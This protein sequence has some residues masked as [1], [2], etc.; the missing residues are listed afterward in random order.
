MRGC[1]CSHMR[2]RLVGA[3]VRAILR[4]QNGGNS[5]HPQQS[6]RLTLKAQETSQT[7]D[8]SLSLSCLSHTKLLPRGRRRERQSRSKRETHSRERKKKIK[9]R[10]FFFSRKKSEGEREPLAT[11]LQRT[12]KK[13]GEGKARFFF[14]TCAL[15]A[16]SPKLHSRD[17]AVGA[18]RLFFFF[19]SWEA[20]WTRFFCVSV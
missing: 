12:G 1:R 4:A 5:Q 17:G 15:R 2:H 10:F 16:C 13:R 18:S 9:I 7:T 20:D 14:F 11:L 19:L 3:V 8:S 6:R